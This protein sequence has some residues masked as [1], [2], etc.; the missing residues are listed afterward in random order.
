MSLGIIPT[1]AEAH[2][3]CDGKGSLPII[4]ATP[5]KSSDDPETEKVLK[6]LSLQQFQLALTL[7]AIFEPVKNFTGAAGLPA[8]PVTGLTLPEIISGDGSNFYNAID[9]KKAEPLLP[10]DFLKTNDD[11]ELK[12]AIVANIALAN[13]LGTSASLTGSVVN[14]AADTVEIGGIPVPPAPT[15]AQVVQ[16]M[17][18]NLNASY[19]IKIPSVTGAIEMP[20]LPSPV[21]PTMN[22]PD[23]TKAVGYSVVY[24]HLSL[25]TLKPILDFVQSSLSHFIG[26]SFPKASMK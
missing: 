12:K 23:V 19:D 13:Y 3:E 20:S 9:V 6:A 2:A 14:S 10:P 26:F 25:L 15:P 17:P 5:L 4:P 8:E 16:L 7:N 18:S 24:T 21:V 1:F 22:S 11:P